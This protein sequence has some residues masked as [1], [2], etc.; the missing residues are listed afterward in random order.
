MTVAGETYAGETCASTASVGIASRLSKDEEQG[1]VAVDLN[2]R[3][4]MYDDTS[5]VP[6][7]NG[8]FPQGEDVQA[9]DD[10]SEDSE[11]DESEDDDDDDDEVD[12]EEEEERDNLTAGSYLG[13]ISENTVSNFDGNS[14]MQ[15]EDT[16]DNEELS[17]QMA[18]EPFDER[19]EDIVSKQEDNKEAPHDE[20]EDISTKWVVDRLFCEFNKDATIGDAAQEKKPS[21]LKEDEVRSKEI[22]NTVE[23]STA[24]KQV[25]H[26]V[27]TPGQDATSSKTEVQLPRYFDIDSIDIKPEVDDDDLLS[28]SAASTTGSAAR[29]PMS[30]AEIESLLAADLDDERSLASGSH[31]NTNLSS[32]V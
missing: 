4:E 28:R 15:M 22:D 29:R 1:M 21:D 10:S 7:W 3:P 23:S 5:V 30:I 27:D 32:S 13:K 18:N 9:D 12:V 8:R 31:A 26:E 17:E 11:D 14:Q 2:S 25:A 16:E 6:A 19:G 20:E 24:E